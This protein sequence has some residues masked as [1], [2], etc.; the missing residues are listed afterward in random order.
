MITSRISDLGMQTGN[1]FAGLRPIG[2]TPGFSGQGSLLR[3]AGNS[4]SR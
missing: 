4:F 2:A 3:S 1:P